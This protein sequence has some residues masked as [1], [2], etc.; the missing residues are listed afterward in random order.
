V[1]GSDRAPAG[2]ALVGWTAAAIAVMSVVVLA[3]AGTGEP[4]IR[5]LIRA[6]A[7]TSVVLFTAAFV[8]SPLRRAWPG[9]ASCWL[10]A[11]RRYLGVSFA[12]SHVGHLLAILALAGWSVRK[13]VADAG[14]GVTF[15]GGVAYLFVVAMT[16][17]SFDRTAAWLGPRR[18]RRLHTA[19][20]WWLW[21]VFF[22]SFVPRAFTSPLYVPFALLLTGAVVLRLGWRPR[23]AAVAT[24]VV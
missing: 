22:A 11:N 9:R 12:V 15:L 2:W 14:P 17:T 21:V 5:M 8:A 3:A 16:A 4:G 19:G 18:W 23:T 20:V 1:T 24:G 13:M 6:T 7:R 10:L